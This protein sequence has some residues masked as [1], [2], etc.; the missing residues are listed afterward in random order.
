MGAGQNRTGKF[1]TGGL[2]FIAPSNLALPSTGAHL[3]AGY[4]IRVLFLV[5]RLLFGFL[6]NL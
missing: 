6:K 5:D 3:K 1:I 2:L 4:A